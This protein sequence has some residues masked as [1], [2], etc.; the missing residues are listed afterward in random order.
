MNFIQYLPT[1]LLNNHSCILWKLIHAMFYFLLTLLK[2]GLY[3]GKTYFSGLRAGQISSLVLI[4]NHF[5]FM[6][7]FFFSWSKISQGIDIKW[8]RELPYA[9][10]IPISWSKIIAWTLCC[11]KIQRGTRLSQVPVPQQEIIAWTVC[12]Q[13]KYEVARLSLLCWEAV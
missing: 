7:C 3:C 11:K 13:K 12:C 2:L 5:I 6:W 8:K 9:H 10:K 1:S 4:C